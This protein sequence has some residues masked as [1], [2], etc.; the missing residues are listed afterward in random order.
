MALV[1]DVYGLKAGVALMVAVV[2]GD[3]AAGRVLGGL[4]ADKVD[5]LVP[6]LREVR[7]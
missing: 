1:G 6:G 7:G 2:V 5:V 3:G 4:A